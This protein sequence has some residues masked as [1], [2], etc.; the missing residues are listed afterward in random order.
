M[1]SGFRHPGAPRYRIVQL[2][3]PGSACSIQFGEGMTDAAPGSYEGLYL[4]TDDLEA[5]RTQLLNR[6]VHVSEPFHFGPTGQAPGYAPGRAD[7]RS[8]VS[9]SDP[10]GNAWLIQE[11]RVRAPGR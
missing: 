1:P 6:G 8:F 4:V 2:T 11:I 5:T 9:F 3:P 10:D 7:Y